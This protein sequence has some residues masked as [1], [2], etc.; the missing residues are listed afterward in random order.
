MEL[1]DLEKID[2]R[3]MFK[4]YDRWPEIASESFEKKFEKVEYD[5]IDHIVFAGMG[6]SGS[7]GDTIAA[8][9]S[10]EDIHISNV[11]GFSLPKTV[12]SKTLVVVTSVSGITK[13]SLEILQSAKKTSAKIASFSSGG[14]VE[15]FCH[16][17]DIFF[18]K[19]SMAHSPRAS[20]SSF[21]FSILNILEPILPISERDVHEA[22]ISLVKTREE[23]S[24]HNLNEQNRALQLA[25]FTKEIACIIYPHG[26]QSAA[27]RYKNS[28]QENTKIHAMTENVIETCH[29]G[30]VAW[31][32]KSNVNPVLL[33]GKDDHI[34]TIERWNILEGFFKSNNTEYHVVNSV[35]G[36][37][38]SKITNLVYLLD[39]ASIYASILKKV[40]PSPVSSIDFIKSKLKE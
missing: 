28:L 33:R 4:T 21:L 32:K 3:G 25:K 20:Y 14:F 39:Y 10:K 27:T 31:E 7:I 24:S 13:E 19:I 37:I 11:K 12:D 15:S 6:G 36:S 38:L 16:D 9:L 22:L 17:N 23:I 5:D 1:N 30:I 18:Q 8:I 40:D 26:L 35:G 2:A 34:R 29:N